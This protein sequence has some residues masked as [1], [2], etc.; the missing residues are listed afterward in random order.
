MTEPLEHKTRA[1]AALVIT[2]LATLG[3][4]V[5]TALA[6]QAG[7]KL[8][9]LAQ[10]GVAVVSGVTGSLITGRYVRGR[11]IEDEEYPYSDSVQHHE[12]NFS[13]AMQQALLLVNSP[14]PPPSPRGVY[15]GLESG[16]N[17]AF[18]PPPNPVSP[19]L[20]LPAPAESETYTPSSYPPPYTQ[21]GNGQNGSSP[22]QPSALRWDG[23]V[24]EVPSNFGQN[25]EFVVVSSGLSDPDEWEG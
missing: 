20:P 22:P 25:G 14:P 5:V 17:S 18:I 4:G 2:T 13:P 7:L 12:H 16:H 9:P 8:H 6:Q 3:V 23:M 21:N 10:V 1:L 11:W 24:S 15:P 19:P